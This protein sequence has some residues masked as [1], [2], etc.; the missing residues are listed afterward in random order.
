MRQ[1]LP[2]FQHG[3]AGGVEDDEGTRR[4]AALGFVGEELH[5]I[6][7]VRTATVVDVDHFARF[8]VLEDHAALALAE[9][10][11]L[12][13]RQRAARRHHSGIARQFRGEPGNLAAEQIAHDAATFADDDL[14]TED[15]QAAERLLVAVIVGAFLVDPVGQHLQARLGIQ[16]QQLGVPL[17]GRGRHPH[18]L[19]RQAVLMVDLRQVQAVQL[20][21]RSRFGAGGGK[22]EGGSNGK[23]LQARRAGRG[24]VHGNLRHDGTARNY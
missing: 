18:A 1:A 4:R 20:G 23:A 6:G 16:S 24:W 15:G 9:R 17:R 13:Q 11:G 8:L 12:A 3:A 21:A 14:L 5:D 10:G 2:L 22:N 7:A 19:G